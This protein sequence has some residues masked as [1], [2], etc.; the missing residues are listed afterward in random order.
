MTIFSK[1]VSDRTF[2]QISLSSG[3]IETAGFEY[4]PQHPICCDITCPVAAGKLHCR[5][6]RECALKKGK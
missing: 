5:R 6:I 3:S 2:L 1:K 4:P